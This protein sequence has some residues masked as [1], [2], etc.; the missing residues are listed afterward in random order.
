MVLPNVLFLDDVFPG[1]VVEYRSLDEAASTPP[2]GASIVCFPLQPKPH[3][4][5]APWIQ[6]HWQ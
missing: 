4:A 5:P 6:Q 1:L 2:L 3:N